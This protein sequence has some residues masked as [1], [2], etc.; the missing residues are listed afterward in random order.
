MP[1]VV[2]CTFHDT[3]EV[4][5]VLCSRPYP[6]PDHLDPFIYATAEEAETFARKMR[7][8]FGN[9]YEVEL[10]LIG[11][12]LDAG[13]AY[14]RTCEDADGIISGGYSWR[15]I[16]EIT[17]EDPAQPGAGS[18]LFRALRRTGRLT[19]LSPIPGTYGHSR[20]MV[21]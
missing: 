17:G 15:K 21:D 7:V 9:R 12:Q 2:Y 16:C 20:F 14:L 18:S 10:S 3:P 1:Y 11:A 13:A 19:D 8:Q 4:G 5:A 6:R